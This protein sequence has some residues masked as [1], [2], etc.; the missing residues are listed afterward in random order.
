VATHDAGVLDPRD[1]ACLRC[2]AAEREG[3]EFT[4]PLGPRDAVS[5]AIFDEVEAGRGV[6]TP[7][8]RPAVLLDTTRVS[9]HDADISLP[10]MLRRYRSAGIDP[11][12]EPILTFPVLHYQNGG[13]VI[14]EH[15][16]TTL[17]GL[18]A[19]G[20]IAGGTHGRNRMM[21]NSLLECTVF[22]RRAAPWRR[23]E[24]RDQVRRPDRARHRGRPGLGAAYARAL[25]ARGATVVVH[26]A[27]VEPD[28]SGGD[29][30]I[31]DNVVAEITAAGGAAVASYEN[32]EDEEAGARIVDQAVERFGRLDV[33]VQNAGLVIWE[34]LEVADRSW[35]RMR[36][37]SIDAPFQIT[38]A[39][40]PAMKEQGYG[41]FVFTTSGRAM[42]VD[43]TRPGLAAYAVGKMAHFALMLVTAAEGESHGIHAN[44]ISPAAATRV[45]VRET[46]PGEL[47]PEQVVPGVLF[48]ASEE[49]TFSGKVL[50]A[51]GGEFDVARWVSS[52]EVDF[53]RTPVGPE[54]IAE[55]WSE[56]EG[57]VNA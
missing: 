19:C 22:G 54:V 45:L 42:A 30:T 6:E 21:G 37:V 49:C 55:R 15:G 48:L 28:G 14:D 17:P 11:L 47:E 56:I 2:H 38:R 18:F 27:G 51:A 40:F 41:R 52:D 43:R 26:D 50:E 7:D 20:E 8:G 35:D 44:A 24:P 29:P 31:A 53:G 32:L 33:V 3:E 36:R 39:A 13:L 9:E 57:L 34:E 10:Y 23:S 4:D 16:E 46:A 12:R 5:Q 1:H 25:A